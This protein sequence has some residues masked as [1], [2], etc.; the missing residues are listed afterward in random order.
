L[1]GKRREGEIVA[2]LSPLSTGIDV[3]GQQ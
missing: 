2:F 1:I 3:T